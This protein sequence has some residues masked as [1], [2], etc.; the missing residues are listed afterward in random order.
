MKNDNC[1]AWVVS[2]IDRTGTDDAPSKVFGVYD[3]RAKAC[4][5][6][7]MWLF[8][9]A[10]RHSALD[11][12]DNEMDMDKFITTQEVWQIEEFEMNTPLY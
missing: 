5:C 7:L 3:S 10:S 9:G 4:E 6:V 12:Y 1:A 2:R 11:S 8:D